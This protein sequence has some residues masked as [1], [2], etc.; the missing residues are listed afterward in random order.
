MKNLIHLYFT[1]STVLDVLTFKFNPVNDFR[2][3][4]QPAVGY[5]PR[6]GKFS[7]FITY[8]TFGY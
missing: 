1:I 3:F 5:N 6:N 7:N 2:D 8:G 4:I